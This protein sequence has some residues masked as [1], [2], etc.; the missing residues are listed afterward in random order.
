MEIQIPI[1]GKSDYNLSKFDFSFA[2]ISIYNIESKEFENW[3]ESQQSD[4][5]DGNLSFIN[6]IKEQI[7]NEAD[8]KYAIIKNNPKEDFDSENIYNVWKMLL[9]IFPSDLQIEYVINY[10][11]EDNFFQRSFMST[12]EEKYTGEYPG[13]FLYSDDEYLKEINEFISTHFERL[14]GENYITLAIES[15]LTS[16]SASHY[17]FQYLTLCMALESVIYGSHELTYRLKRSIGLLCGD[18]LSSCNKIYDNINKIYKVRSKII[19][20]EKYKTPKILEYLKPL[21]SL[22]S[23]TII[24]LLVHN[25][26]KKEELDKKITELGYGNRDIISD[27][28]KNYKLNILTFGE[29]NWKKLE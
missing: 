17:H 21:K 4:F 25:I 28:Y 12:N 19:H 20:G 16:F 15:Y 13:E 18:K 11:Y 8:K 1:I 9:I 3:I 6:S 26:S 29:T 2:D 27:N 22:V 10:Q 5:K 7:H 24:E 23:R 14:K